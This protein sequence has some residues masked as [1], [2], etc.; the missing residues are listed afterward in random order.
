MEMPKSLTKNPPV[1]PVKISLHSLSK[2]WSFSEVFSNGAKTTCSLGFLDGHSK[3][4]NFRGMAVCIFAQ[5]RTSW[6]KND[7]N[8][9]CINLDTSGWVILINPMLNLQF[10][11]A[12]FQET[13]CFPRKKWRKSCKKCSNNNRGTFWWWVWSS[14]YT[15]WQYFFVLP[16]T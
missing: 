15:G 6:L 1:R 14:K 8:V 4:V 11:T 5:T 12:F 3:L 9:L 10:V 16:I 7:W 13:V 2:C